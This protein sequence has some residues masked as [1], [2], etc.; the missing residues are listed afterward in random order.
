MVDWLPG[1]PRYLAGTDGGSWTRPPS[2]ICLHSTEGAGWDGYQ[3]GAV[4]PHFTLHPGTGETRQHIPLTRA[5]R[6][7]AHPAGTPETNRAGVIQIE[8]IGTSDRRLVAPGR[9]YLGDLDATGR[10]HIAR[11]LA[12]IHT[13]TGI[14]LTTTVTW[15]DYPASYG[16][17][18]TQRLS[19]TAFAA[20][21]GVLA[22]QHVP[23]NDHGDVPVP[24]APILEAANSGLNPS[25]PPE[26]AMTPTETRQLADARAQASAANLRSAANQKM[27]ERLTIADAYRRILG[28][29]A[30]QAEVNS[31]ATTAESKGIDS[32]IAAI[33]GSDEAR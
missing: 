28:R 8:I 6:A 32:V 7:L 14:P 24:I 3:G 21:R 2:I 30:T 27:L 18:A 16:L 15:V 33:A 25:P 17:R 1:V 20:Y 10:G 19:R 26:D 9:I 12:A 4:A 31:W 13:A 29:E 23:D 22:H 11:L 5:A